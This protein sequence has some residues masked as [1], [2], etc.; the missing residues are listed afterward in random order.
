MREI[1]RAGMKRRDLVVVQ[2][3]GDKCLRGVGLV[4]FAYVIG[5]EIQA[6]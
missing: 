6:K 2:V 1:H 3:G 5:R 4:D